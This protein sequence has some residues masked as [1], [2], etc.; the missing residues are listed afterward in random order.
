[1]F[2]EFEAGTAAIHLLDEV[3]RGALLRDPAYRRRFRKQWT[4]RWLPR[5][6]HR[7]LARAEILARP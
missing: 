3:R 5:A 6:F 4:N 2:E 1:V 7:D